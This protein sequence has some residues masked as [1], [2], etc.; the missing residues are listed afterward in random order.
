METIGSW[1][2][3]TGFAIFVVVACAVDLLV[4]QRKGDDKVSVG[5]ALRWSALWVVL[6]LIFNALLWWYIDGESGRELANQKGSEFLTGYIIEKSL[7][8]DNI[9]VFLMLFTFF[10][11]PPHLQKRC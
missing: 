7:A 6:A 1:W 4:L 8:V 11:V 10:G 5:Q 9:F 3:W 2:M